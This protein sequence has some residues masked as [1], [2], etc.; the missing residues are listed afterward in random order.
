MRTLGVPLR[1]T[2]RYV[3]WTGT[4]NWLGPNPE[5]PNCPYCQT[6]LSPRSTMSTRLSTQ[7]DFLQL[8]VVPGGTP[9][10]DI[11]VRPPGILSA[12]LVPAIALADASC[13]PFPNAHT[14]LPAGSISMTRLFNWSVIKMFPG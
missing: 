5:T 11:S 12:S 9:V 1:P 13:G 6:I 7:P 3:F 2:G 4:F 10:P 14:M 8:V